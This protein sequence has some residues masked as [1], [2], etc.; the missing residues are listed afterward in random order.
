MTDQESLARAAIWTPVP[1]A[2]RD[3]VWSALGMLG[4]AGLIALVIGPPPKPVALLPVDKP[5][6]TEPVLPEPELP[7]PDTGR[8][9][10]PIEPRSAPPMLPPDYVPLPSGP[11]F[12]SLFGTGP[13][14]SVW[15]ISD[16]ALKDHFMA[17]DWNRENVVFD[18]YGFALEVGDGR[19][20]GQA[21]TSGEVQSIQKYGYGRYEVLMRPS[22]DSGLI[23]SFFTYT[24]PYF[25]DP[26]DEIDIEFTGKDTRAVEFN[27]FRNGKTGAHVRIDLPFDAADALH[28]YAFEWRPD[29]ISWYVDNRLVYETP[30][31]DQGIPRTPSKIYMNLWTGHGQNLRSWHGAPDFSLGARAEYGCVSF[32][33]LG[34]TGRSCADIYAETPDL[35]ARILRRLQHAFLQ[36]SRPDPSEPVR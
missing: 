12:I 32:T 20:D 2:N 33:P 3:F 26:H 5:P 8:L 24:G 18:S 4:T 6:V 16:H 7:L 22:G 34:E 11:G 31:G 29:R 27:Y 35:L 23:S 15:Y 25:G 10:V 28:L 13:E 1:P 19:P 21:W 30:V 17:N 14:P 36:F 9:T